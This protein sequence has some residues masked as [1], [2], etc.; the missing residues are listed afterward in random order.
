MLRYRF[1]TQ[2]PKFKPV[3]KAPFNSPEYIG[4]PKY[5]GIRAII[6]KRGRKIRILSRYGDDIT[7]HFPQI[8]EAAKKALKGNVRVDG[9]ITVVG[10]KNKF[11]KIISVLKSKK[12]KKIAVRYHV[13]DILEIG[14]KRI[15]REPLLEKRKRL[16]KKKVKPNKIVK[17]TPYVLDPTIKDYKKFLKE[18][19]EG[20]VLKKIDSP[21]RFGKRTID[22]IKVKPAKTIDARVVGLKKTSRGKMSFIIKDLKG[23]SLG[24]VSSAKLTTEQR[25]MLIDEILHGRKPRVEVAGEEITRHHKIRH[26]RI[27]RVRIDL[28]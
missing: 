1:K 3:N 26:P 17:L 27:I 21:Y 24:L 15:Y 12:P 11:E 7:E 25:K 6:E 14:D 4:E 18:G 19:Y 28:K 9:E 16:L 8:V 13:F 23:R 20:I 5:D 10:R 2:Q 22:W